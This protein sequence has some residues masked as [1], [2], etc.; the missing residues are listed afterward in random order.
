MGPCR[1]GSVR[2]LC[3]GRTDGDAQTPCH[4]LRLIQQ[5]TMGRGDCVQRRSA[6]CTAIRKH[7]EENKDWRTQTMPLT[8]L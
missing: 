1:G 7:A 4:V 3:P 2:I 8:Q 6:F 5:T